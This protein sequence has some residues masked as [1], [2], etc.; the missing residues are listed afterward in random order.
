MTP[1]KKYL[2]VFVAL[3]VL[4]GTLFVLIDFFSGEAKA[5]RIVYQTSPEVG[6]EIVVRFPSRVSENEAKQAFRLNPSIAGELVWL[7][8]YRELHFLPL[9]GFR[10][11]IRYVAS[12][13]APNRFL[14]LVFPQRKAGKFIFE[15]RAVI[16]FTGK[17]QTFESK[18]MQGRYL[19]VN[20]ETMTLTLGEDGK[21]VKVFPLAGKG[22]PWT[23]PT[24]EGYFKVL[25]KEEKHW[26]RLYKV[27]L[28]WAIR[29][30]EGYF[31]HDIPYWPNGQ[32]LTTRYS[33]G[34][35][36]LPTGIAKEVYDWVEI[37]TPVIVHSTPESKPLT[38]PAALRDGDLV[39]EESDYRVF[40]IKHAGQKRFK[41]HVF[42]EK[43]GEWYEHLS[44][45]KDRVQIVPDGT[46]A[47]YTISSWIRPVR[48]Q[49]TSPVLWEM[50]VLDEEGVT[51]KIACAATD[52]CE[53]EWRVQGGDPDAVFT[54]SE[55]E[56]E[57]Y[58]KG[59]E[60]FLE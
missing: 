37:G 42:T 12:V 36:R 43:I 22:N 18:V 45:F 20:I 7:E 3:L 59:S 54:V 28:P 26:S 48:S 60:I 34:C 19:D 32:L 40:L 58:K 23:T 41:R 24:A 30:Y 5:P 21:A 14:A 33:G 49:T 11:D 56:F 55:K 1:L 52:A 39:R 2:A 46:L 38:D 13:D 25:Q 35:V 4:A 15:S 31:I 16:S 8:E 10:A 53:A 29:F 9:E 6:E 51:H 57:Y 47:S 27:W 50:Y 17:Y 44:P